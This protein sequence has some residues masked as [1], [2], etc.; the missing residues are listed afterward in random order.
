MHDGDGILVD[1][2]KILVAE[3]LL[4]VIGSDVRS[5]SSSVLRRIFPSLGW[6]C[7]W[8]GKFRIKRWEAKQLE[9]RL[10]FYNRVVLVRAT[11]VL[12]LQK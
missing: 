12:W 4:N 2:V 5:Q 8:V 10:L 7:L 3:I 6:W 11:L 1:D 9:R